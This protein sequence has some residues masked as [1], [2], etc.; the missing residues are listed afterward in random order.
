M[1]FNSLDP[2]IRRVEDQLP[3]KGQFHQEEPLEQW[4][5]YEVFVQP[6]RGDQHQHVGAVHAPSP[7]LA[8]VFAKEQFARR[9]KCVNIWVVPTRAIYHTSAEDEDMFQHAVD[10]SY[11][12]AYGYRNRQMIE[13]FKKAQQ[14][15]TKTK[16]SA[17]NKTHQKKGPNII[18]D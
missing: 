17:E 5:T 18:I 3:E 2:R 16:T 6:N 12:E 7:E 8:I 15:Q 4:E 10:K 13:A 14:E 1:K 11:R 9:M